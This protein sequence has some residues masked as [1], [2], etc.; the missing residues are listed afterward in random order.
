MVHIS[1]RLG[2]GTYR[3]T[4]QQSGAPEIEFNGTLDPLTANWMKS[5]SR[6]VLQ[7]GFFPGATGT[8]AYTMDDVIMREAN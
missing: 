8:D 3:M 4:I 2:S 6:V 7:A 1:L 5:H